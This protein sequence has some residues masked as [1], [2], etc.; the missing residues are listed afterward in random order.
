MGAALLPQCKS[1]VPN[2]EKQILSEAVRAAT[3]RN[4]VP[5]RPPRTMGVLTGRMRRLLG[6]VSGKK[7]RSSVKRLNVTSPQLLLLAEG[8]GDVTCCT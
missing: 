3:T 2:A 5:E 4:R 1:T 7:A 6:T 8:H